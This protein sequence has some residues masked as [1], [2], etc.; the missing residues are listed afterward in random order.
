MAGNRT[1]KPGE[2]DGSTERLTLAPGVL[3]QVRLR[4]ASQVGKKKTNPGAKTFVIVVVDVT[5]GRGGH[6]FEN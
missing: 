6:G 4:S 3:M 5:S 2:R 1:S